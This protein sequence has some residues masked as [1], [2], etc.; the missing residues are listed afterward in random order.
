LKLLK[1]YGPKNLIVA[2]SKKLAGE[3]AELPDGVIPFAE[4]IPSREVLRRLEDL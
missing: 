3:D 4:V 2:V 1:R